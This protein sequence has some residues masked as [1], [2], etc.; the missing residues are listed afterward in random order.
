MGIVFDKNCVQYAQKGVLRFHE[1]TPFFNKG[2]VFDKNGCPYAPKGV[3]SFH[4]MTPFLNEGRFADPFSGPE[5]RFSKFATCQL[6][7]GNGA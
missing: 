2:I 6:R 3:N 7:A 1:I 5:K 4:K